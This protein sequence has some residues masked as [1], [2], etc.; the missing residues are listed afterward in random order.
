MNTVNGFLA[1][2]DPEE[3]VPARFIATDFAQ[4]PTEYVGIKCSK[5]HGQ[6]I[7]RSRTSFSEFSLKMLGWF[8]CRCG[9]CLNRFWVP[10]WRA[11]KRH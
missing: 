1:L 8:P 11:R 7:F 3:G 4:K 6:T 10:F 2:P 9:G 5:C